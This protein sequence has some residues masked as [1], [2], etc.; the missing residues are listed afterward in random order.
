MP[1]VGSRGPKPRFGRR[2]SNQ[3]VGNNRSALRRVPYIG[4]VQSCAMTRR[5]WHPCG[6]Y[7]FTA[8]TSQRH[9]NDLLIQSHCCERCFGRWGGGVAGSAA[10]GEL[11][12]LTCGAMRRNA[13]RLLRPTRPWIEKARS[14]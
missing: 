13:L 12:G 8:D 6:T 10:A 5:V 2:S 9:G 14:S 7:C 3:T 11:D 4:T 1:Y